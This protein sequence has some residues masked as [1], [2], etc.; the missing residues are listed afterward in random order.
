MESKI[1]WTLIIGIIIGAL[2]FGDKTKSKPGTGGGG[3]PCYYPTI[4]Q[5]DGSCK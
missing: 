5:A 2:L 1:V 3:N 4:T